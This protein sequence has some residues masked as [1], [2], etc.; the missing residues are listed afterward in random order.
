MAA[1]VPNDM[2]VVVSV[3]F[4]CSLQRTLAHPGLAQQSE[5]TLEGD[6]EPEARDFKYDCAR[7]RLVPWAVAP[8]SQ[9][10]GSG[11]PSVKRGPAL[12]GPALSFHPS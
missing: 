8:S 12:P 4:V 10:S 2:S 6:M 5:K 3:G 11:C 1:N 9:A 7:V